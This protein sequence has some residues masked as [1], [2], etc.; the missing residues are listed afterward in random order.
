VGYFDS[1]TYGARQPTT[2]LT[3]QPPALNTTMP[4]DPNG[5][6]L[7]AASGQAQALAGTPG[8]ANRAYLASLLGLIPGRTATQMGIARNNAKDAT[9]G[10]GGI[11]WQPDNPATPNVDESLM[12]NYQPDAMGKNERS[13]VISAR[14]QA[15]AHGI[16]NSSESD[17]M[18]GSGLQ[19]VGE[20]ARAII[21]Q[22]SGQINT[23]A[24]GADAQSQALIGQITTAYGT[25]AAYEAQRIF[26]EQTA[27]DAAAATQ[28]QIAAIN[29]QTE[30]LTAPPP[31]APA[32]PSGS[33]VWNGTV[34]PNRGTLD[35]QFGP[36][37]YTVTRM[38]VNGKPHYIVTMN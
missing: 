20:Q 34:N 8:E 27:A 31:D 19:R 9:R 17:Q 10:F 36:G 13:A 2:T 24:A 1:I 23:I 4:V 30:V 7:A 32:H 22:Y 21:N 18:V 28:A 16:L 25:D 29:N 6:P 14:A 5:V 33:V 35:S 37:A 3:T 38:V 12:V 15:A 26:N 11:N